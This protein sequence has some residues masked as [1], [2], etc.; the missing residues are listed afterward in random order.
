MDYSDIKKI[1]FKFQPETAH[2]IAEYGMRSVINLPFVADIL[3]DKFCYIDTRLSQNILGTNFLNPIGLA[4]GFD[5]NLTMAKPLSCF[6]FGFLEYGTLTPKPQ[7]GNP[8]PRL[9]RLIEE[10]SLQNAMGFNN[11]GSQKIKAR[12]QKLYP[13]ALPLFANIGKNKITPNDEAL[14]DY[15]FLVREFNGLCDAFVLNISSPNTPNLRA[16]QENSFIK[17]LFSTLKPLTNLP[18][19]LKIAPDMEAKKAIELCQNALSFGADAIIINNTSVDYTLSQNA[20]N[21]GG[22]SGALIAQ[23][24]KELFKA[25]ANELF[26]K[27]TLISCGGISSSKDAYERIKMGANLIQIYTSFIFEG[28]MICKKISS[29]LS[30]LLSKDGFTN[31]T[32]AVG[33]NVGK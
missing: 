24:S 17:E 9:F 21:F 8:K 31:I 18:I 28:P 7:N 29:E 20:K 32:Q 27:I 19:I 33:I 3:V 15:E 26:G 22:I 14:K 25:I 13:F 23:K 16:L 12:A 11:D 4:G 1:F 10:K 30:E 5:K 6:G 2:K